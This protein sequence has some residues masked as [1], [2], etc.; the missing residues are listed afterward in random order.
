MMSA[1][2]APPDQPAAL[3]RVAAPERP[4]TD[5]PNDAACRALEWA[6]TCYPTGDFA[7]TGVTEAEATV[8]V[9]IDGDIRIVHY[10]DLD[11]VPRCD[12]CGRPL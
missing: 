8:L 4:R 10:T 7:L 3:E 9:E 11:R 6:Q 12:W 5:E 1:I 2:T